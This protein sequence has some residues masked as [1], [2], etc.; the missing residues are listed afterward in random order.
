[1]WPWEHAAVGYLVY[2]VLC[3]AYGTGPA[4]MATV[5]LLF[6]TQCPD[7]VDKPLGW[8]VGVI[9]SGQ[10]IAHS[11]FVAVGVAG[12][13]L[14]IAHRRGD[15]VSQTVAAAFV[16]G[17]LTHLPGDVL[18]PVLLG[19]EFVVDPLLWPLVPATA[20]QPTDVV[21][22]VQEL[23]ATFV[24]FLGSPRGGLYL[25]GEVTLL[26]GAF[27]LWRADGYPGLSGV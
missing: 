11:L 20:P 21:G 7:L 8:V 17:Y 19:G 15:T 3:R 6:G 16:V 2:S 22:Y 23:A 27:L 18:Y 4:P 24:T 26:A 1:M 13:V 9:P 14:A 10:S 12:G 5:A 25:L